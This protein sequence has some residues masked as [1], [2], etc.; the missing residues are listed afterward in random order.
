MDP[1]TEELVDQV[2]C[3]YFKGPNSFNGENILELSVHGNR[4]HVNKIIKLFVRNNIFRMAGTGEFTY[5][6][7]RNNKLSLPQ[8][9]G[10]DLLLNASSDYSADQGLQLLCG[11]LN[12]H[13]LSLRSKYLD[14]RSHFELNMDFSEDVGEKEADFNFKQSFEALKLEIDF[15][16][17]R[18]G[19]NTNFVL[20]PEIVLYGK[21]NAGKSSLFN[22]LLSEE[23][24]IV[25]S[26]KGTTRDYVSERLTFKDIEFK[27]LDTAGLR[28]TSNQVERE[29]IRRGMEKVEKSFFFYSCDKSF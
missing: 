24:S 13:F 9:E 14:M 5:R 15:L 3:S 18:V 6:A 23:R 16:Y 20:G 21:V 10:L 26:T 25:S 2:V 8:V 1:D 7:L 19:A 29:G 4:I 22:L 11:D 17:K 27:I 28:K 12:S